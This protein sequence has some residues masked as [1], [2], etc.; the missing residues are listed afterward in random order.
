MVGAP[1]RLIFEGGPILEAPL[2]QDQESRRPIA[3]DGE[4]LGVFERQLLQDPAMRD[5]VAHA[6][7][8]TLSIGSNDMG[9][10]LF[11]YL[12]G[13]CDRSCAEATLQTFEAEYARTIGELRALT[14]AR[15]VALDIYDPQPALMDGYVLGKL[16]DVNAL[17][18]ETACAQG[19]LVAGVNAAFNGPDGK[20]NP[21]EEGYV[22]SDAIHP[23]YAGSAVIAQAVLEA[24]C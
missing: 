6:D 1:E 12:T 3:V 14:H 23:S 2:E 7:F 13:N 10:L 22:G 21:L 24:H 4:T 16:A 15:I 18:H 9:G 17:I 5:A 20:G 8:V 11:Q 19:V